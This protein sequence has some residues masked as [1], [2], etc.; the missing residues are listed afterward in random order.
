M[1]EWNLLETPRCFDLQSSSGSSILLRS[2]SVCVPPPDWQHHGQMLWFASHKLANSERIASHLHW[3]IMS[4]WKNGRLGG[5][6]KGRAWINL[7]TQVG[8]R[9]ENTG[10]ERG[11]SAES[12]RG[13]WKDWL[14]VGWGIIYSCVLPPTVLLGLFCLDY[15]A[16]MHYVHWLPFLCVKT[17]RAQR[18][19]QQKTSVCVRGKHTHIYTHTHHIISTHIDRFG[20]R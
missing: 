17:Y 19:P 18:T 6:A 1:P 4:Q 11:H 3:W 13:Q 8:S 16:W 12:S 2:L 14:S 15:G 20:R 9:Q 7:K 10:G 5:L